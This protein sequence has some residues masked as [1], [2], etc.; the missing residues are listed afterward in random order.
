M[1]RRLL[2]VG[3]VACCAA[4]LTVQ[5]ADKDKKAPD[6]KPAE[7]DVKDVKVRVS[8]PY[9]HDNLTV[10]LLHA[11]DQDDREYLTLDQ[12]L[13]QKAVSVTEQERE[14]VGQLLIENKS[15]KMLFLQEGDRVQG[16]KQDRIIVT[17]LVIPP[18]SGKMKLPTFCV[19]SG[20][21]TLSKD[22]K[23]FSN[24]HNAIL[25]P[26]GIRAA[27]KGGGGQ[28]AVWD[29]VARSKKV[30]MEKLGSKNTNTS[31][32]ETLDSAQVKKVCE[33]CG[34]ALNDLPAKHPD[35]IGVA[36]AVNGK[37]EEVD[38]YPN[39][40]LFARLFPR[41]VQ[42]FGVQAALEK[43]ALKGKAAP[44]VKTEDVEKFMSAGKEKDRRFEGINEDNR[45]RCR[46]LE[47]EVEFATAYKD[48]IIHRQ[49]LN[50]AALPVVEPSRNKK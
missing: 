23:V 43:D 26:Q 37:V 50:K 1:F 16:G 18:K 46:N 48:Q 34:K 36:I 13:D 25:A 28:G 49:W 8:G 21:W 11:K 3:I 31:L 10:F 19:E 9:V 38:V 15:D 29:E 35:A 20:R 12:G 24:V 17:S 40:K 32:N 5:A 45:I 47:N 6:K 44:A 30:T 7:F 39:A 14:Q 4:L 2:G 27:S 42:S 33:A 41:L 22:G